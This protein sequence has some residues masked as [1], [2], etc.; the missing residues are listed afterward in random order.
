[1]A[2]YTSFEFYFFPQR[3][4]ACTLFWL[5]LSFLFLFIIDF[6][7]K[8]TMCF[9]S[10]HFVLQHVLQRG[11]PHERC[12]IISKVTERIVQ[13]SQHKFASNVVEKCLEYANATEQE[14]LIQEILKATEGND[15]LLVCLQ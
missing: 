6:F 1:M 10:F 3:S 12:Q 8:K 2:F 14:V 4:L 7:N 5:S 9:C 11:K 15:N 13:M